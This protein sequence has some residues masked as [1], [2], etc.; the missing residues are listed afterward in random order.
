MIAL[1]ADL[2]RQMM[3]G[4]FGNS[5]RSGSIALMAAINAVKGG[6]AKKMIVAAA[7]T[8][9]GVPQSGDEENFGDGAAALMIG[10]ENVAVPD[11]VPSPVFWVGDLSDRDRKTGLPGILEAVEKGCAQFKS[12]CDRLRQEG[13]GLISIYYHPCE[14][15]HQQ[16]WDGVNFSRGANPPRERWKAP[17]QRPAQ[18][19]HH[20]GRVL[21]LAEDPIHIVAARTDEE[22][23]A[24]L[25]DL[26][27]GR[28]LGRAASSDH[29]PRFGLDAV[30]V[31]RLLLIPIRINL[32]PSLLHEHRTVVLLL[33]KGLSAKITFHGTPPADVINESL[34]QF[35]PPT[36]HA[37]T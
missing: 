27:A 26:K 1:A 15:V 5:L 33:V 24:L 36:R 11:G 14:W 19:S 29:I 23:G 32:H 16:F 35:S 10:D 2:R 37:K 31:D 25:D 20:P 18:V 22:P 3:T 34:K 13:G 12:I 4:D 8:R 21:V 30:M 28:T 17:P 6:A 7:D 9:L